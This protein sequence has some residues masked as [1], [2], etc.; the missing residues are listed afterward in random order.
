[1]R[2]GAAAAI[3]FHGWLDHEAVQDVAT[4]C[5]VLAFPSI[6]EFGGGVVLEAMALG[7]VP[8]IVDYAGP[9]E[10]VDETVGFK[11]PIGDRAAVVSGFRALLETILDRRPALPALAAQG[12][13]RIARDYHWSRK[14]ARIVALYQGLLPGID[15][16]APDLALDS[17]V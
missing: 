5:A 14:A 1:M 3:R 4:T 10:L 9:G 17:T 12:Q 13:A 11:T 15:V 6:R 8:A 16:P 2:E 7:L